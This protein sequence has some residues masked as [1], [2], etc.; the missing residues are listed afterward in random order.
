MERRLIIM[1]HARSSAGDAH[2]PDH[3]RPLTERGEEQAQEIAT[4]LVELGWTPQLVISSDATR[5]RQ[6]W[7]AMAPTFQSA[8]EVIWDNSL[9]L[10]GIDA[11]EGAL[12]S[13]DDRITDVLLLGHNPGWQ[14]SISYFAGCQERMNTANAALL[15]G[16]GDTWEET[17]GCGAFELVQI[18]RP[19]SG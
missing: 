11:I 7:Q 15:H 5:T 19:T 18:L 6:T 3:A 8:P 4:R 16:M 14:D 9:Y 17:V 10:A 13:A 12:W 2:T 1:R